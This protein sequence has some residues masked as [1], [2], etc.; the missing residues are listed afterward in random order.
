[1]EQKGVRESELYG[2]DGVAGGALCRPLSG[3]AL[4]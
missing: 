1:M 4:F 2:P 3:M